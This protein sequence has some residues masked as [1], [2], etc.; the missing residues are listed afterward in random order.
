VSPG[1]FVLRLEVARIDHVLGTHKP[2]APIDHQELAVVAQIGTTPPTMEGVD[3]HHPVP[4]NAGGSHSFEEVVVT[5][6]AAG[7]DVVE[8][9]AHVDAAFD[10]VGQGG[11]KDVGGVV[12]RHDV[13]LDVDCDLGGIHGGG[14]P[15]DRVLVV[16]VKSLVA[17]DD[18]RHRRE[19]CVQVDDRR[20]P[21]D[22][23][24]VLL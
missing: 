15:A 9:Q 3:R 20:Q 8:E 12:P 6:V 11:E 21:G 17:T 1:L 19:A 2:H 13:D 24:N 16:A 14:H 23:A 18:Q 10:R 22:I 4:N 5:G 7:A